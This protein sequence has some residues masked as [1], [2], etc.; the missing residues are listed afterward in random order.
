M[1]LHS[2]L[3]MGQ[4]SRHLVNSHMQDRAGEA[5][6][7]S[8]QDRFKTSP[9]LTGGKQ[10]MLSW[11]KVIESCAA[12]P[13]VY[14]PLCQTIF[15][16]EQPFPYVVLVPAIY[17]RRHRITEKLLCVMN[18]IFYVWEHVGEKTV[19]TAYPLQTIR[20]LEVGIILLYSWLTVSGTTSEG[21]TASSTI[22]FNTAT[23]RYITPFVSKM[24]PA[25]DGADANRLKMEQAK[26]DYQ[27]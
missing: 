2:S 8:S 1:S 26:F 9:V 23:A 7:M 11:A 15:G 4:I 12:L 13:E 14:Q 20:D 16:D 3:G 6:G 18:D 27:R 19:T 22:E 10:T 21:V 25:S 17:E 24:R 5:Y